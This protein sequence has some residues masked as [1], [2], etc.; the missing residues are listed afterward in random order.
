MV[1]L[2]NCVVKKSKQAK[3]TFGGTKRKT[4]TTT[5]ENKMLTAKLFVPELLVNIFLKT[6]SLLHSFCIYIILLYYSVVNG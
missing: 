4:T 5:I 3:G 6:L 1:R 2:I